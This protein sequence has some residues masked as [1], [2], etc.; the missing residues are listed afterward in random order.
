MAEGASSE[1]DKYSARVQRGSVYPPRRFLIP[2]D[3]ELRQI[4]SFGGMES[5]SSSSASSVDEALQEGPDEG[6]MHA[7]SRSINGPDKGVSHHEEDEEVIHL[8]DEGLSLHA[9][10]PKKSAMH[11]DIETTG[12]DEEESISLLSKFAATR[13]SGVKHL[14]LIAAVGVMLAVFGRRPVRPT[15]TPVEPPSSDLQPSPGLQ[16]PEP[17]QEKVLFPPV[18]KDIEEPP[19]AASITPEEPPS[20]DI[21]E[22]ESEQRELRSKIEELRQAWD[23]AEDD[24]LVFFR[25][26]LA[27]FKRRFS[28]DSKPVPGSPYEQILD[29]ILIPAFDL[30]KVHIPTTQEDPVTLRKQLL[31][32]KACVGVAHTQLTSWQDLFNARLE[33]G[34]Q[35]T[36]T[37]SMSVETFMGLIEDEAGI[38]EPEVQDQSSPRIRWN[39]AWDV[40]MIVA[41]T[42]MQAVAAAKSYEAFAPFLEELEVTEHPANDLQ[43]PEGGV[44]PSGSFISFMEKTKESREKLSGLALQAAKKLAKDF[45]EE[46][47][48]ACLSE[49]RR[50]GVDEAQTLEDLSKKAT[51]GSSGQ[52]QGL[53]T[54]MLSLLL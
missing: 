26:K 17:Q 38:I 14:A 8:R 36:K 37:S 41:E 47:A 3:K 52:D 20:I 10:G 34:E 44:F 9:R 31:L 15:S 22:L 4:S 42:R 46:G 28:D 23:Q 13:F 11:A 45:T 49:I 25:S 40:A 16:Q 27:F 6:P 29:D 21:E 50:S 51:Q 32:M 43:V 24:V 30:L 54:T 1:A 35:L 53:Y 39:L 48:Q 18:E 19:P 7:T 12:E 33:K 2:R 5:L